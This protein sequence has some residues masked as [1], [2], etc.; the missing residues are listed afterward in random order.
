[1]LKICS[2]YPGNSVTGYAGYC[3]KSH[4]GGA[5]YGPSESHINSL[6]M[7]IHKGN[8]LHVQITSVLS[9]VISFLIYYPLYSVTNNLTDNFII[10]YPHRTVVALL[11][12]TFK[13]VCKAGADEEMVTLRSC[14]PSTV[15]VDLFIVP[16]VFVTCACNLCVEARLCMWW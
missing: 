13:F 10:V 14:F 3:F 4:H 12:Q 15:V 2:S 6:Y 11:R 16:F 5:F 8:L 9:Q 7:F 1:M